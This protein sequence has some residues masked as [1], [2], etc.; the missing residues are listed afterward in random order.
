MATGLGMDKGRKFFKYNIYI[1]IYKILQ[2]KKNL[3]KNIVI[4]VHT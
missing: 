1:I 2:K 4:Y 3:L